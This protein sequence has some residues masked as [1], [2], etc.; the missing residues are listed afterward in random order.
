ML[1][2]ILCTLELKFLSR[3]SDVLVGIE[4]CQ[5]LYLIGFFVLIHLIRSEDSA[6]TSAQVSNEFW[7][8]EKRESWR[9]LIFI[10]AQTKRNRK[11]AQPNIMTFGT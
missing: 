6:G 9:F 10:R 8:Q 1:P 7:M 11:H 5:V 2:R 3:S 4:A